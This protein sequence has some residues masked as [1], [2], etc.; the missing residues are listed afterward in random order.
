MCLLIFYIPGIL[1]YC[2]GACS[3]IQL[4]EYVPLSAA[5]SAFRYSSYLHAL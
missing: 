3:T 4:Y 2:V 1:Y 5:D